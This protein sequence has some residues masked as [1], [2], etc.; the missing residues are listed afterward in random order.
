MPVAEYVLHTAM[1]RNLFGN[2]PIIHDA[3]PAPA[4]EIRTGEGRALHF[5]HWIRGDFVTR[6]LVIQRVR[7]VWRLRH[8]PTA[9]R[10]E[11]RFAR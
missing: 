7:H 3:A 4:N 5:L 2:G 9:V 8:A 10:A 1:L 6:A 11:Y